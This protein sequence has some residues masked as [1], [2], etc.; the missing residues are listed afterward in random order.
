MKR[1]K[2]RTRFQGRFLNPVTGLTECRD[3]PTKALLS[4]YRAAH[5]IKLARLASGVIDREDLIGSEHAQQPCT[6]AVAEFRAELVKLDRSESYKVQIIGRIE[7]MISGCRFAT[8]ADINAAAIAKYLTAG[9]A[10]LEWSAATYN[11]H[12]AAAKRF[13]RHFADQDRM[14]DC[15]RKLKPL[16]ATET[17]RRRWTRALTVD[18]TE[19]LLDM[20][21]D[22]RR[23]FYRFRLWT[24]IR[25]SE[26]C[27]I[28]LSDLDPDGLQINLRAAITKN[29]KSDTQP[30]TAELCSDLL[31][32]RLTTGA[33]PEDRIFRREPLD[34]EW[35][36]DRKAAGIEPVIRGKWHAYQAS[37]RKTYRT[38]LG[39]ARVAR[40]VVTDLMRHAPED[41]GEALSFGT[42]A[43]GEADVLRDKREGLATMATWHAGQIASDLAAVG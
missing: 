7:S 20:A 27:K 11:S 8:L 14:A 33:G 18:E 25:G 6:E 12:L 32:F 24:G 13:T 37:L 17:E 29:R 5:R 4:E 16:K 40:G 36:A 43:D 23:M 15:L 30:I 39:T 19:R 35:Q 26:A 42:Y 10:D 3:F 9:R 22:W 2:K 21:S 41:Q 38:W 34:E 31:R 1:T 28:R